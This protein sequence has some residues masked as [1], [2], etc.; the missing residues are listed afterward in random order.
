M[1]AA[2]TSA[3]LIRGIVVNICSTV[4]RYRLATSHSHCTCSLPAA[5][6]NHCNGFLYAPRPSQASLHQAPSSAP[7]AVHGQLHHQ[8]PA[9]PPTSPSFPALSH[10]PV[11][12][13][14]RLPRHPA[15][16]D[17][18]PAATEDCRNHQRPCACTRARLCPWQLPLE[19]REVC[20]TSCKRMI[21]TLASYDVAPQTDIGIGSSPPV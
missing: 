21:A 20:L 11:H 14:R 17:S 5:L 13:R 18:A 8:P 3:S 2:G 7:H 4:P 9:R 16:P 1:S 19:F 6:S 15:Q 10:S 12:A